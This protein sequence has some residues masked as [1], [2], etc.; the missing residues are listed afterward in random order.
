MT[1]EAMLLGVL[2]TL[3]PWYE[4]AKREATADREVRLTTIANAIATATNAATCAS[5]DDGCK[6][7]WT[8]AADDHALALVTLGWWESRFA[9][10]VHAD[11]CRVLIGEC[12]AGRAKSVWQLQWSRLVPYEE[13]VTIGGL[14]RER[15]TR[16]AGAASRVFVMAFGRCKTFEG[17]FA[18]YG[19]GKT[20]KM[21]S[22]KE[23]A[24][25]FVRLRETA[26]EIREKG[27]G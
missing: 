26:K 25:F 17:A 24:K 27:E 23:R 12:D 6:P 8:G 15:T 10:H 13:W 16:A 18:L 9:R 1:L 5:A 4:D 14:S 19:T 2:L 22:A 3:Q 20:C 11:K 7:K 21:K